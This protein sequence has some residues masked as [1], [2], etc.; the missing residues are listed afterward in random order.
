M[1][2]LLLMTLVLSM[3]IGAGTVSAATNPTTYDGVN[4]AR[5]YSYKYYTTNVHPELAG[6]DGADVLKYFV[7]NG[8]P[9]GEQAISGFSVKSYRN[10]NHDLREQY[11]SNYRSYILQYIRKGYK[12]DRVKTGTDDRIADPVT[13]YNGKSY[14]RVYDF[15]YYMDRYPSLRSKYQF[16]DAGAIA[17]FVTKGMS[18]KHQA[19]SSFNVMWYYNDK[20]LMRYMCGQ[21][22]SR[23]YEYYQKS[24]YKSW[25]P[26][27]VTTLQ[28]PITYYKYGSKKYDLSQ[29][30]DFE[31]FTHHNASAAKFWTKQDDA[32]A[33][34]YFVKTGML[35][36]MRGNAKYGS[37][38]SVYR[39]IKN[40]IFPDM[41]NNE[42][43]IADSL[44]SKT[45]YL[46]LVN[47]GK[48]MVYCFQGKQYNWKKV[49]EFP[50]CVGK[51]GTATGV[52]NYTI[53]MK[54]YYFTTNYDSAKCWWFSVFNKDQGFH[55][56]IYDMSENPVHV[57]DGTMGASVSHGCVRLYLDNAKWIWDRAFSD[58]NT[59]K[60]P[61]S[62]RNQGTK[63]HLYNRPWN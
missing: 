20:P 35:Q 33:V 49:K 52:G 59:M 29:I 51:P 42:Y 61:S 14:D 7:Q 5:V 47:Q 10:A 31:Y 18:K 58:P 54:R 27:E 32:G 28:K 45:N 22:W 13:T 1:A 38:S 50:C 57:I 36:G 2:M 63:V 9:A 44:A 3:L 25:K 60:D 4:Y 55:S 23:Y 56:V 39:K 8:I 40:Q 15:H 26:R 34:K 17:Y 30:Y 53:F 62:S 41:T 24:G 16:D 19:I 48:H 6:E 12:E 43:A 46:I 37:N 11:G 21:T